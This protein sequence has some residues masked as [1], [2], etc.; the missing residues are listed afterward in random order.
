MPLVSICTGWSW[1][2]GQISVPLL[3]RCWEQEMEFDDVIVGRR[4]ILGYKPD[5][6]PQHRIE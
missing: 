1:P 3:K 4:S 2:D 5:A 6:V